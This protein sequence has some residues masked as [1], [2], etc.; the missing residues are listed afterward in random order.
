LLAA[1]NNENNET[2][3]TQAVVEPIL[4]NDTS[5]LSEDEIRKKAKEAD[6]KKVAKVSVSEVIK[7]TDEHG[8]VNLSNLQ[9]RWEDLS[10]TPKKY[11]W[12]QTKSGEWFKGDIIALYDD[13]LEFDSDEIGFYSFDFD[14]VKRVKS[15]HII[16]VNIENVAT[17]PGILRING[18]DV[19]IIQGDTKYE[20]T[21]KELVSFAPK[22]EHERNLWSGKATI[23]FDVR[24][25]NTN[26]FDYSSKISLS[27]RTATSRLALDYL[28]RFTSKD[29]QE[30]ANDHRINEKYDRYLTRYFFWT[31]AFSE[32]YKDPYKNINIQLTLGGGIGY[33]LI[34]NATTSWN[35]SGGP[36]FLYTKYITVEQNKDDSTF[37]P[38]LELST[39]YKIELNKM[40]DVTY[41]YKFTL[42]DK[43]SGRYKH[44]ML[45]TLENELTSWLDL[46]ITGVWDYIL[47]PET[48]S[49]GIVPKKSDFQI[50]IG[51]GVEF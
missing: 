42:T 44:H 45:I 40:T 18:D 1:H 22:G 6:K 20:F 16:G 35:I 5:G 39:R 13:K 9:E 12:V 34:D 3:A 2:N 27:R 32:I 46:D 17:I 47:N 8:H 25:G 30:I 10:P 50:L 15:Y 14:D 26:Q 48:A 51:F 23:S 21:R 43:D 4:L 38:A 11:D 37:S 29:R 31:P 33:T 36:A 49:D 19:V 7:N 24:N 28:G 41:D